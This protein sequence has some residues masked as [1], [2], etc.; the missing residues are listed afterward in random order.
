MP[1]ESIRTYCYYKEK[2]EKDQKK[3]ASW[4][5][6]HMPIVPV[7]TKEVEWGGSLAPRNSRPAWET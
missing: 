5:Q 4:V 3:S 2:K 6:W 1:P 7:A